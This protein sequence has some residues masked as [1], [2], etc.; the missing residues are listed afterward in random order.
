M[1]NFQLPF[2]GSDTLSSILYLIFF[3]VPWV[4]LLIYGQRIQVSIYLGQVSRSLTRLKMLRDRSKQV[5][6]NYV[7]SKAGSDSATTGRLDEFLEYFIIP[8]VSMDPIGVVKRFDNV[9]T[10]QDKRIKREIELL[11]PNADRVGRS[12][13]ESMVSV[14]AALNQIFKIVRHYYFLGKKGN[15]IYLLGQLQMI[16]PMLLKQADAL[17]NAM[18]TLELGQPLGDGIGPMAVGLL[19]RDRDKVDIATDTVMAE[20]EYKGRKLIFLKAQGPE[21]NIG[22]VDD[23]LIK[24]VQ[25]MHK[26]VSAIIMIDAALKLEGE[27]TGEVAEGVGAAIG[28]YGIE[29]FKIEQLAF[30]RRIPLY[31]ILVKVSIIEA[32]GAMRKEIADSVKNVHEAIYRLIEER[33]PENAKVVVLG[34]GNSLG[35][36]Q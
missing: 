30:E 2:L 17:V 10:T 28:G 23:A 33:V 36:A 3:A 19:M 31:A 25:E 1:L 15:N 26:D 16:M 7:V 12:V 9:I 4:V 22:E 35:I 18:S 11:L 20:S 24:I 29:K 13:A 14:A 32:I 6:T 21:G 5:L 34:V 8:P 27:K